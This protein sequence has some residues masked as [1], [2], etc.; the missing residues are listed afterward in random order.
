MCRKSV[1]EPIHHT[2]HHPIRVRANPVIVAH[3]TPFRRCFNI[4]KADCN[5]Y[6]AA[7]DKLIEDVEPIPEKYGGF[8]EN[9]C[10]V[11]RMCIPR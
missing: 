4:R 8:I 7:I 10:V 2:Q 1:M 6:S 9:V 3:P 5:G 11:S